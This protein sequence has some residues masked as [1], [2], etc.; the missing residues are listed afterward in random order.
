[1]QGLVHGINFEQE[2]CW[3]LGG[4]LLSTGD[5]VEVLFAGGWEKA[6]VELAPN[7]HQDGCAAGKQEFVFNS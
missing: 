3:F 1:M 2:D 6:T 4:D 5:T 7:K